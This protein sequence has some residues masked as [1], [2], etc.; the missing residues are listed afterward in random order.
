MEWHILLL[1][2]PFPLSRNFVGSILNLAFFV[3]LLHVD[4][5]ANTSKTIYLFFIKKMGSKKCLIAWAIFLIFVLFLTSQVTAG[6]ALPC[7]RS[8]V[9][10][11]HP[12]G[13]HGSLFPGG[14]K[15]SSIF[16]ISQN[17]FQI[18]FNLHKIH[19]TSKYH[20]QSIVHSAV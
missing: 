6:R 16:L 18:K 8:W 10:P 1:P 2:L 13:A 3:G 12:C 7:R 15:G 17:L 9:E 19:N 4:L 14:G 5:R 11:S 20:F